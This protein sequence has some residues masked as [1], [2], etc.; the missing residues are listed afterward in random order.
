MTNKDKQL[1]LKDLLARL[2]Y[3]VRVKRETI[4]GSYARIEFTLSLE[5]FN[6]L[7]VGIQEDRYSIKPYL[8]PISSMTA[9]EESFYYSCLDEMNGY[10]QTFPVI[11]QDKA[12]SLFDWLNKNHFDYRGL[13]EKGLALE[14]KE[15][16]YKTK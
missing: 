2:P 4:T 8:R 15:E 12:L 11:Y 10:K 9:K 6:E 7:K 1:V 3:G 5:T 14:A 13:I 16:M